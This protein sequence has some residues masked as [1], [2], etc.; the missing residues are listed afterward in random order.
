MLTGQADEARAR[1]KDMPELA[2]QTSQCEFSATAA[3]RDG[4]D[5]IRAH[6]MKNHVG[7]E[8]DGVV[9]GVT[10]WGCY[11]TLPNTVEGLVHVKSL[12]DYYEFDEVHQ[13]LRAEHSRHTLKLGD[14]VRV[15][16]E[17]VNVMAC[18]ID[19]SLCQSSFHKKHK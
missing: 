5:L 2:A 16:L 17:A 13:I 8:F 6:Y 11:V 15:K 4:D 1:A 18:E 12:D 14:K 3:E 10:T 19:F 7:E 9:S